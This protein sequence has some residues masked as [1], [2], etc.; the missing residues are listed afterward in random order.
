[1]VEL[2]SDKE[3]YECDAQ[4]ESNALPY[5]EKVGEQYYGVYGCI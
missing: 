1:M 3:R 5:Y 2:K 4:A